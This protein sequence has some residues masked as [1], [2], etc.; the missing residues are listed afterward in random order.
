MYKVIIILV[1]ILLHTQVFADTLNSID[2]SDNTSSCFTLHSIKLTNKDS[3]EQ[4]KIP[5][6]IQKKIFMNY[7]NHCIQLNEIESIIANVTN[8]YIEKGYTTTRVHIPN[9]NIVDGHLNLIVIEGK[10]NEIYTTP[11]TFR[12]RLKLFMS[13]PHNI[14]N[15]VLYMR[16]IEQGV[17]QFNKIYSNNATI[18]IHPANKPGYS[19]IEVINKSNN[20]IR[21]QLFINDVYTRNKT[22]D[23]SYKLTTDI[24]NL[25]ALNE[26]IILGVGYIPAK[27]NLE[28]NRTYD[29]T[30]SIPFGYFNIDYFISNNDSHS[31]Y[32]T[33]F[34]TSMRYRIYTK[35][36][37]IALTYTINRGK[38]RKIN[39]IT[40]LHYNKTRT[41][42]DVNN[43][44]IS[45]KEQTGKTSNI[46]FGIDYSNSFNKGYFYISPIITIG[47]KLFGAKKDLDNITY[48]DS[49]RQFIKYT[50]FGNLC[51]FINNSQIRYCTNINGQYA[52]TS[53]LTINQIS[54]GSRSS[55]RGF[56]NTGYSGDNGLYIQNNLYFPYNYTDKYTFLWNI[57]PTE[58][59]IGIDMGY[60][61]RHK[62]AIFG[63]DPDDGEF[64]SGLA[65][66][67]KHNHNRLSYQFEAAIPIFHS[68]QLKHSHNNRYYKEKRDLEY[69][70]N[71]IFK[72][73]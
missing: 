59:Y 29:L 46:D 18:A 64:L 7:I 9:Q 55:I 26:S 61:T 32:T 30:L 72:L 2:K 67:I 54:L 11:N 40:K 38:T 17:D 53:L 6:N 42:L 36:Q 13:F 31:V 56:N 16:D 33:Q 66:G 23:I 47:S 41:Y 34:Y 48:L 20:T 4:L 44:T 1:L 15:N 3:I 8:W 14:K 5:K 68:R 51:Y 52:N 19:K 69:Y 28:K 49:H 70:F 63:N 37:N 10:I 22:E 71:I 21:S 62:H 57:L 45:I 65:F 12:N 35:N 39:L 27:V 25:F 43:T 50:L 58:F 60:A 73:L 24:D